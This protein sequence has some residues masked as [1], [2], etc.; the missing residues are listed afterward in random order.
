VAEVDVDTPYYKGKLRVA[1]ID[2]QVGDLI[3]GNIRGARCIHE[4]HAKWERADVINESKVVAEEKLEMNEVS[5]DTSKTMI[6]NGTL[7]I[8]ET[9]HGINKEST[10]H[11]FMS[12]SLKVPKTELLK[13]DKAELMEL[14]LSDPTLECVRKK[15]GLESEAGK[16]GWSAN[17]FKQDDLIYRIHTEIDQNG[18]VSTCQLVVP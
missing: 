16:N 5:D 18:V 4:P 6:E 17:F 11:C 10:G 7:E 8:D 3:I 14:Q 1:V 12:R 15:V 2:T 13:I 9:N